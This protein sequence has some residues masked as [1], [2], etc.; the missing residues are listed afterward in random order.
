MDEK[1]EFGDWTSENCGGGFN[2]N[3]SDKS[4]LSRKYLEN[5]S[6]RPVVGERCVVGY[7]YNI[8]WFEVWFMCLPLTCFLEVLQ[9][10]DKP[11]PPKMVDD[12]LTQ[13]PSFV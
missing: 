2:I 8:S 12:G 5:E 11:S 6:H 3:C 13:N 4:I 9:V 7:D 10:L 1:S